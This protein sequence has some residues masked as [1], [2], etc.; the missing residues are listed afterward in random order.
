MKLEQKKITRQKILLMVFVRISTRGNKTYQYYAMEALKF[1]RKLHTL[2]EW[3]VYI[4]LSRKMQ[5]LEKGAALM[6]QWCQPDVNLSWEKFAGKLDEIAEE[7]V[8][9]VL[10]HDCIV[11]VIVCA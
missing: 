1:L 11:I 7:V 9:F 8:I 6:L 10:F 4:N 2:M 3:H 5:T